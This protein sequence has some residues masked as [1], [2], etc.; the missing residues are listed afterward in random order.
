MKLIKTSHTL[1]ININYDR[2]KKA[3]ISAM[4]LK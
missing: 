2:K 3:D 4:Y 1:R